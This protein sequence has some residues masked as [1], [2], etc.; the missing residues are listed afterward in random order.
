M[1]NI[2]PC[3]VQIVKKL[4]KNSSGSDNYEKFFAV[5]VAQL[6]EHQVVALVVAGSSPVTHPILY[7]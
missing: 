5:G 1:L 3:S 2:I 4:L 7:L 6:V